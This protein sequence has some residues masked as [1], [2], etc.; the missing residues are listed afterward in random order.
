M[1]LLISETFVVQIFRVE[2][3]YLF[4]INKNKLLLVTFFTY[5]VNVNIAYDPK[6]TN[7]IANKTI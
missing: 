5:F 3:L 6:K 4:L 2:A 1:K 7:F